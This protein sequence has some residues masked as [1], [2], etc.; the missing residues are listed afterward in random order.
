MSP[1]QLAPTSSAHGITVLLQ[2][3]SSQAKRE[4]RGRNTFK[5][6]LQASGTDLWSP[7]DTLCPKARGLSPQRAGEQA[8][9]VLAAWPCFPC[10]L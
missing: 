9:C 6:S 3:A 7:N 4:A 1:V 5:A 8:P 2:V 10:L